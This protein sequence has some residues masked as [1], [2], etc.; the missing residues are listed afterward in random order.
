VARSRNRFVVG[1]QQ[2]F[3]CV[4]SYMSRSIMYKHRVLQNSGFMVRLYDRQQC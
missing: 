3:L 2:C 4:L 1:T